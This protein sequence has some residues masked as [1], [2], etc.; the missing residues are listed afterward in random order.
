MIGESGNETMTTTTAAKTIL[1]VDDDEFIRSMLRD[2]LEDAG[3]SVITE[4]DG[5]SACRHALNDPSSIDLL[6]CD[7]L[8]PKINGPETYQALRRLKPDLRAIFISGY[9]NGYEM[10]RKDSIKADFFP[11]PLNL[12]QFIVKIQEL[13]GVRGDARTGVTLSD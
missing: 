5:F 6:V 8:M 3:F 4:P 13:L 10:A 1:V 2:F 12:G 7:I 9:P 11:K